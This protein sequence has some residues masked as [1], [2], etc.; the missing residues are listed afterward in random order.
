MKRTDC[1]LHSLRTNKAG[2]ARWLYALPIVVALTGCGAA[3]EAELDDVA[4]TSEPLTFGGVASGFSTAMNIAKGVNT[5]LEWFGIHLFGSQP[6]N[7]EI[8][9][10]VDE[11]RTI[12]VQINEKVDRLIADAQALGIQI[13]AAREENVRLHISH[14]LADLDGAMAA[15]RTY[16]FLRANGAPPDTSSLVFLD[17]ETYAGV[18]FFK[19]DT[20]YTQIL[21]GGRTA[22]T[23]VFAAVPFVKAASVRATFLTTVF[24]GQY[25]NMPGVVEELRGH[26]AFAGHLASRIAEWGRAQCTTQVTYSC[27]RGHWEFEPPQCEQGR[28]TKPI[29]YFE[30]DEESDSFTATCFEASTSGTGYPS[31]EAAQ[32]AANA[33]LENQLHPQMNAY[34]G[35]DALIQFSHNLSRI[36]G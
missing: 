29:K 16:S 36:A 14:E 28:C 8:L 22:W 3:S 11:V 26:A 20:Y 24:P 13:Q 6:S 7:Q 4:A 10:K 9:N 32:N 21:P 34:L 33:A 25:R 12:A 31:L 17:F 19:M 15:I 2:L 27:A 18:Q 30:C 23:P 35:V 1:V 5:A